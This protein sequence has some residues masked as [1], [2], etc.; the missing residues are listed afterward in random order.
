MHIHGHAHTYICSPPRA[1]VSLLEVQLVLPHPI[2]SHQGLS[3]PPHP[4]ACT[5]VQVSS[6]QEVQLVLEQHY[7][8]EPPPA[9]AGS[10]RDVV[11]ELSAS[12]TAAAAGGGGL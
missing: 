8:L 11:E 12:P 3:H 9:G 10:T 6:L 7:A 1:Q 4:L 2:P 5:P